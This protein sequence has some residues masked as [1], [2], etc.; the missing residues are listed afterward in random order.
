MTRELPEGVELVARDEFLE[1][2]W[3]YEPGQHVTVLAPT[4]GGKT[5]LL[6]QL[7]VPVM[8]P[9]HPAVFLATKPRDATMVRLAADNRLPTLDAWPPPR[10]GPFLR[11]LGLADEKPGYVF[12]P[13]HSMDPVADDE[14]H[15]RA[16]RSVILD[17]YKRGGRI[18]VADETHALVNELNVPTIKPGQ[19]I[20]RA[21]TTVWN[22][23]RSMECGLW[24]ATQRPAN[25]PQE[26]YSQA[27]HLFLGPDP[28][29]RNRQRFR[30]I[31]GKLPPELIESVVMRL[32]EHEWCYVRRHP[33]GL[34]VVGR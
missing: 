3:H 23:G 6:G 19:R 14:A 11:W 34:C 16:F 31:A 7:A 20:E 21:M 4:N 26:M 2:R 17:C 33:V 9:D 25:V 10:Q 1:R 12:W 29:K 28:D 30:E 18:L 27:H 32:D 8:R 15:Y 13:R 22:R 5:T 24:A